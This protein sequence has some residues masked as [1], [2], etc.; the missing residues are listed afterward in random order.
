MFNDLICH[1]LLIEKQR[2]TVNTAEEAHMPS[3][4]LCT[5]SK[6]GQVLD[7]AWGFFRSSFM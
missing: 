2:Q 3:V 6:D 5:R 1:V 7:M 4:D